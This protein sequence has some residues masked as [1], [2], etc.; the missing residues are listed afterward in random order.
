MRYLGARLGWISYLSGFSPLFLPTFGS[1][2]L[3]S[4][5]VRIRWQTGSLF[6]LFGRWF[7]G[8]GGF[9]G[10]CQQGGW[11]T[12]RR[13]R[14]WRG[15]SRGLGVALWGEVWSGVVCRGP[16]RRVVVAVGWR[17]R[18]LCGYLSR[19]VRAVGVDFGGALGL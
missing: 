14:F 8:V 15:R 4:P 6:V 7:V 12:G 11:D 3:V 9:V 1:L 16:G 10:G 13:G 19:S 2:A 5:T 17:K 18:Q